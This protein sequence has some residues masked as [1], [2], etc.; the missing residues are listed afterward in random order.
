MRKSTL[1]TIFL[2]SVMILGVGCSTS[3]SSTTTTVTDESPISELTVSDVTLS[4]NLSLS[5]AN[6]L[7]EDSVTFK[8]V[9]SGLSISSGVDIT[10]GNA[11]SKSNIFGSEGTYS[12]ALYL[13][14]DGIEYLWATDNI[15]VTAGVS[16]DFGDISLNEM[17]GLDLVMKYPSADVSY[18]NFNVSYYTSLGTAGTSFTSFA[19]SQVAGSGAVTPDIFLEGTLPEGVQIVNF[20]PTATLSSGTISL[21]SF[22]LTETINGG[23][24]TSAADVSVS[25][26]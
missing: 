9:T 24:T 16:L 10:T 18:T 5:D 7:T 21:A 12:L 1:L 4:A 11:I 14:Q 20:F 6:V 22:E 19:K 25:I 8:Y 23:V 15:V 3:S 26:E 17:G 2:G 13:E